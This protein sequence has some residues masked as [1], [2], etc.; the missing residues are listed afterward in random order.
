MSAT[1]QYLAGLL[2]D[3]RCFE[4]IPEKTQ[5]EIQTYLL[6]VIAQ[7]GSDPATLLAQSKCLLCL[8]SKQL[9]EIKVYLL[10]TLAGFDTDPAN[11]ITG[12]K[13]YICLPQPSIPNALTFLLSQDPSGPGITSPSALAQAAVAFQDLEDRSLLAIQVFL[14]ATSAQLPISASGLM[15]AAKCM[16]CFPYDMLIDSEIAT[17]DFLEPIPPDSPRVPLPPPQPP[18]PP[19]GGPPPVRG[20]GVPGGCTDTIAN[21]T[22]VITAHYV[23]GAITTIDILVPRT[24]CKKSSYEL[25]GSNSADMSGAV[26]VTGGSNPNK[27]TNWT[28]T[29]I[30]VSGAGFKYYAAQSVCVGGLTSP[31]SNIV[32]SVDGSTQANDWANRVVING[33]PMP[34]ANSIS[35]YKTFVESLLLA[36]VWSKMKHVNGFAPDSLIAAETPFLKTLGTRDPYTI[37]TGAPT[38]NVNGVLFAPVGSFNIG[39]T[40]STDLNLTNQG[41]SWY[42]STGIDVNHYELGCFNVAT[43]NAVMMRWAFTGATKGAYTNSNGGSGSISNGTPIAG[44]HSW[45]RLTNTNFKLYRASSTH[46]FAQDGS[47]AVANPNGLPTIEFT[48]GGC[49]ID[50]TTNNTSNR[51]SFFAVHDGLTSTEAQNLYNAVQA[52]RTAFGGGF[53]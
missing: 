3:A 27:T 1:T 9:T 7:T 11:L 49:N 34:S 28:I 10:A 45:N 23:A 48:V 25:F 22:P 26:L 38:V 20:G 33:G 51:F 31:F 40:P 2:S 14:L 44:F 30:D 17:L 18:R 29:G 42:A 52:L 8:T 32:L 6:S 35:A 47:D 15:A 43:Q 21:L 13:C 39:I 16:Q 24:C 50:G 36:S 41:F 4:C 46:P 12:A 5:T 19:H 37:N 53:V